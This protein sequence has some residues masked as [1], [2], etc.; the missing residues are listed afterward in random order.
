MRRRRFLAGAV[1]LALGGCAL[2]VEGRF[3]P[4]VGKA[5]YKQME[6]RHGQP[7]YDHRD[8]ISGERLV[9]WI[10]QGAFGLGR[11]LPQYRHTLSVWFDR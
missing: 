8:A 9:Q 1:A 3:D 6:S 7:A 5:T 2:S 10:D 11:W 4:L